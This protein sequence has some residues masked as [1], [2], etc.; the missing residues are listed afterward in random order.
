M[1]IADRHDPLL[2][3]GAARLRDL[4][5]RRTRDPWAVLVA[6]VM[7]QQTPVSRV[8]PT[9]LEFL[10]R[11][12]TP[13]R[14]AAVPL[15]DVLRLWQGLGYPRRARHLHLAATEIARRGAFPATLTE[16]LTLPGVGPYTARAVLSF[17]YEADA[18]VV[19]TNV[20]RVLAR[21]AGRRLTAGEV[22]RLAD[23]WLPAGRG[24]LWNQ[25]LV[26][27][28]ATVCTA[29]RA[30]CA[31]CPIAATCAWRGDPAIGDPAA[32]SAGASVPQAR[33]EGSDR[34]ARGRLL[35]ALGAA[36]LAPGD[37]ARAA[38][39]EDD[40]ERAARLARTLADDGLAAYSGD[41]MLVLAGDGTR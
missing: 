22:Q 12:P 17:A 33:F 30:H 36:A 3:W 15:A 40:P 24:W 31:H 18:A 10:D 25:A 35:R 21:Q 26:D 5:W 6:E 4:P 19:D 1:P 14:C 9:Y 29:R 39:L 37:L 32:G 38:G 2:S 13:A 28:G 16:L 8:I 20:A 11:F 34:Q 41:G 27:L 23:H 7:L